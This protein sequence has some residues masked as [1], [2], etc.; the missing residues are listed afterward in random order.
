MCSVVGDL[1]GCGGLADLLRV[2]QRHVQVAV[3]G[4]SRFRALFSRALSR[5]LTVMGGFLL[6]TR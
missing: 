2:H 6:R 4:G 1:G 3:I 5:T